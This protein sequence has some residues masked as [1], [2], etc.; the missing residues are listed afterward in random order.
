MEPAL[1]AP[2]VRLIDLKTGKLIG[3]NVTS[4]GEGDKKTTTTIVSPDLISARVTLPATGVAQ[5]QVTLNNQRFD[6]G[7]PKWPPWKYND[8]SR[9]KKNQAQQDSSGTFALTFGQQIRLDIRYGSMSG[10]AKLMVARVTDLQF[11]FPASGGSQLQVVGEDMLSVLKIKPPKDIPHDKQQEEEIAKKTLSEAKVEIPLRMNG[12]ATRTKA[13][14]SA[15][16][17][18]GQTYFQF[19]ADIADRMDCEFF[20][21]F[22]N[23]NAA[24]DSQG[25]VGG[26]GSSIKSELQIVIEPSRSGT[27]P[28]TK[29]DDW[30]RTGLNAGEYLELRWGKSLID[31]KPK[32]KVW[33]MPTRATGSGSHPD[34]RGQAKVEVTESEIK[35]AIEKELP[36]SPSY[37]ATPVDALTARKDFFDDV[38]DPPDNNDSAHGSGLDEPRLKMKA[39][40]QVMK[41]V[42]E[43]MTA[44]GT[45]IGVPMLRPGVYVHI[46]GLRPPFDGF[47]YVTQTSHNFDASGYRTSFSLRRPGMLPPNAY[48]TPAED[49]PKPAQGGPFG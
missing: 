26:G 36:K 49:E 5:L 21:D 33:E 38:G 48:E 14:R 46:V 19:L 40:A 24:G 42:R 27:K 12:I 39:L 1:Y 2:Q 6:H 4:A 18:A 16:H 45:T 3:T 13:L 15:R 47:Y 41:K 29:V 28:Q 9:A 34:R 43:F 23:R 30:K 32:L 10:W 17:Q 20:V 11:S 7:K 8:F 44:E 35:A 37:D 25:Q 31:F 22:A